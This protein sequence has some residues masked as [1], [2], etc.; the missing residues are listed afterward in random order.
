MSFHCKTGGYLVEQV[1]YLKKE[2]LLI[3]NTQ[4]YQLNYHEKIILSGESTFLK[5]FLFE[6]QYQKLLKNLK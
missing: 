4:R 1:L 3:V 5:Y 6:K 2:N